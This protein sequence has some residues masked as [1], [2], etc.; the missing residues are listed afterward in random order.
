VLSS[1]HISCVLCIC[2]AQASAA[3]RLRCP[4]RTAPQGYR[5]S[6]YNCSS[7]EVSHS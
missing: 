2:Q 5:M 4:C 7:G 6:A 1:I 3:Y